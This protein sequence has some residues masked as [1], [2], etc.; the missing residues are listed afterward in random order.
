MSRNRGGTDVNRQP[1]KRALMKPGPEFN[2]AGGGTLRLMDGT[3]DCPFAFAKDRLHPAEN[4]KV[5]GYIL[6]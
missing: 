1:V 4:M 2:Q 3:G 6:D 5:N